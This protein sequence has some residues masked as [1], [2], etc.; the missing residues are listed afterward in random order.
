MPAI[1][2][3]GSVLIARASAS[4]SS[5]AGFLATLPPSVDFDPSVMTEVGVG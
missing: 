5:G 3:H 4:A 1:G 2:S